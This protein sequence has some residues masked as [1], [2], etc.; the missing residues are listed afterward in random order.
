MLITILF[1]IS[2]FALFLCLGNYY[3]YLR[4]K[5]RVRAHI[6]NLNPLNPTK[7]RYLSLVADK[8]N[9]SKW[10]QKT[11]TT[12]QRANMNFT[13]F[14]YIV[15]LNLSILALFYLLH[16]LLDLGWTFE[17]LLAILLVRGVGGRILSLRAK[18]LQGKM[19]AQ[20]PE[21]CRLLSSSVKAG[22]NIQQG[23]ELV[24]K[25]MK[26]SSVAMFH[27]LARELKLGTALDEALHSMVVNSKSK[28]LRL[29]AN[30]LIIQ[31]KAGGNLGLIL[32]EMA[33]TLEMRERVNQEI[34]GGTA[35]T[36]YVALILPFMP[37]MAGIILNL[38]IPGFLK[39]L[40]TLPGIILALVFGSGI[41]G[42]FTI[43]NKITDIKV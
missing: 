9:G 19:E 42:G 16:L 18:N 11:A 39:P 6:D 43:I 33:K 4:H 37:I 14:T 26:D 34:R 38:V 5:K 22:L 36:R 30:T 21:V 27:R 32:E 29:M 8:Y 35:E 15:T 40:L 13:P 12:L 41:L 23:L 7:N 28:E 20:L 1:F 31:H 10:G 24:A 25:E 17:F 2:I 3:Q